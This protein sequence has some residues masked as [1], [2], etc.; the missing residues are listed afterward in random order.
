[1]VWIVSG[2]G[3]SV[4]QQ[5][6]SLTDRGKTQTTRCFPSRTV[7]LPGSG[8]PRSILPWHP[9]SF[10]SQNSPLF[11]KMPIPALALFYL[12]ERMPF[13]Y[14]P[15]V[16]LAHPELHA[17]HPHPPPT[18]GPPVPAGARISKVARPLRTALERSALFI[19]SRFDC[20]L[21]P[22]FHSFGHNVLPLFKDG[23]NPSRIFI[24]TTSPFRP[25]STPASF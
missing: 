2:T 11:R 4:L 24:E 19:L 16:A 5:I 22:G 8:R 20:K 18:P 3:L 10:H 9:T 23:S 21:P 7:F 1:M 25:M 14:Q 13:A 6:G 15:E 12:A 17:R